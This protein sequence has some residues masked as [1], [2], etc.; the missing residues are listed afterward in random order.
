MT[1]VVATGLRVRILTLEALI[2]TKESVARDKDN[3]ALPILRNTLNELKR[4]NDLQYVRNRWC[5]TQVVQ[6]QFFRIVIGPSL[7]HRLGC[8]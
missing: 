6:D 5:W 4:T 1:V 8:A 2:R 7:N 3:A